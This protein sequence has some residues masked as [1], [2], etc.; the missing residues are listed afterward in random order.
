MTQQTTEQINEIKQKEILYL[1]CFLHTCRVRP[2]IAR[3]QAALRE[4][5]GI[6]SITT[7][8]VAAYWPVRRE[9]GYGQATR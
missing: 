7:E 1:I 2:T 8:D 4:A 6:W 3:A 9:Q 5:I